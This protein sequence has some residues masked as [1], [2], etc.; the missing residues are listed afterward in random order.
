MRA[1]FPAALH[2][3]EGIP[4]VCSLGDVQGPGDKLPTDDDGVFDQTVS[5]FLVLHLEGGWGLASQ[6]TEQ[7]LAPTPC[8]MTKYPMPKA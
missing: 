6:L 3:D 5:E 4:P 7:G 8:L 1:P 2:L